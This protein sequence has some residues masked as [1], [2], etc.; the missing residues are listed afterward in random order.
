MDSRQQRAFSTLTDQEIDQMMSLGE[1]RKI[2]TG[3]YFVREG[4]V[5]KYA[6]YITSGVM[7]SFYYSSDREEITYCFRFAGDFVTAYSSFIFQNETP[8]NIQSITDC[9]L[10][11]FRKQDVDKLQES[12]IKWMRFFKMLAEQEYLY[13]EK[14]IF[15]LQRESAEHRY[16]D[17]LNN[18]PEYL[19][20]I[21]LSQIASYLGITQ[22]HL[23]RIRKQ[24]SI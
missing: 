1:H 21:P 5:C 12:D 13:M 15:L 20:Q 16:L 23:S 24:I 19:K 18:H 22:R 7:R 11:L 4:D 17:L 14:R 2:Q 10:I 9:E 8:E 6:A 3:E